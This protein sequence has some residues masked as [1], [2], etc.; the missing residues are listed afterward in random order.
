MN[1]S[2]SVSELEREIRRRGSTFS[3]TR[4]EAISRPSRA[5]LVKYKGPKKRDARELL[6]CLFKKT[7][8]F[9]KV[10]CKLSLQLQS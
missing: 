1:D 2:Y 6:L 8:I 7:I 5:M 9:F 10:N 3:I 4:L